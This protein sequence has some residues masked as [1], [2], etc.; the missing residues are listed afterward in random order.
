MEPIKA[1]GT[2]KLVPSW[3]AIAMIYTNNLLHGTD[4]SVQWNSQQQLIE[5]GSYI[6]EY[7]QSFKETGVGYISSLHPT[8][9][10]E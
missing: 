8:V 10:D 5:L 7:I 6:D 1:I 9:D 3:N 2:V 4:Y